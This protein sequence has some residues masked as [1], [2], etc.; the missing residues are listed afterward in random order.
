MYKINVKNVKIVY[1]W[2]HK[3]YPAYTENQNCTE[4]E[5]L[6]ASELEQFLIDN[7]D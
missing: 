1:D 2:F 5:I 4:E 7:C 6:L 3:S